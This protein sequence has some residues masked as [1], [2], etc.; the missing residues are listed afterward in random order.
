MH[1]AAGA[2][3]ASDSTSA[4][5]DEDGAE[6]EPWCAL[7]DVDRHENALPKAQCEFFHSI[8]DEMASG[9]R[10]PFAEW[11]RLDV[12]PDDEACGECFDA[13]DFQR[14]PI[15]FWSPEGRWGR[16]RGVKTPCINHGWAHAAFTKLG[17]WRQRRAKGRV[18]DR[19][20][21]GQRVTCTECKKERRRLKEL[22]LAAR[23]Q[24][25]NAPGIPVLQEKLKATPY[26][27]SRQPISAKLDDRSRLS[28][29]FRQM[30]RL[31]Q[32]IH[33]SQND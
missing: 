20:L 4:S 5:R 11:R 9:E 27:F 10:P 24:D 14:M 8:L 30:I 26:R 22:L 33:D 15:D 32:R 28:E 16:S 29:R 23:S 3:R 13:D 21:A 6:A 2:A 25:A 12:E 1:A 31:Q 19:G 18:S 7:E 17:E